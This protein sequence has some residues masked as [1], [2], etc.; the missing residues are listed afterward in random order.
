M[1]TLNGALEARGIRLA[2]GDVRAEAA[3]H[4]ELRERIP[5][6]TRVHVTYALR[7]PPGSRETVERA[8]AR[9]VDKCPTA[10]SLKGAVEVTWSAAIRESEEGAE[11][12]GGAG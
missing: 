7:T 11:P 4:H 9:H 8:L 6:L 12:P 3:G 10:Q 2:P 5:V 1:G